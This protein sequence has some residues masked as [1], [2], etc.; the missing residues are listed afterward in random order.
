[1]S[2]Q[3]LTTPKLSTAVPLLNQNSG[4]ATDYN[5]V[6]SVHVAAELDVHDERARSSNSHQGRI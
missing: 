5:A 3:N 4:D 2:P 1:M 6:L